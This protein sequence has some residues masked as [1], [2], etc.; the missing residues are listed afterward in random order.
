[1]RDYVH[2]HPARARL[3]NPTQAL[4]GYR[5]SSRPVYLK[6][7]GQRWPFTAQKVAIAVRLRAETVVSVQWIAER[8]QMGA[9]RYVHHLLYRRRKAKGTGITNI[10]N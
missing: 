2:L 6:R 4:G 7:A 5:W 9:A 8:M 10:K 3:L 1:M